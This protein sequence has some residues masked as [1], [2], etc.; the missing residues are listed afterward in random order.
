[1]NEDKNILYENKNEKE[2]KNENIKEKGS[3]G[4]FTPLEEPIVS[5]FENVFSTEHTK[6][7]RLN[8]F[9]HTVKYKEQVEEYRMSTDENLRKKIKK[10]LV[11]VTPS[12]IFN[13]RR[14]L[15]LIK[16]KY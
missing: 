13:Q 1:M 11:C 4:I 10:S 7:I 5:L 16:H 6:V 12:G 3:S 8:K 9:L 15:N 2:N 14:E